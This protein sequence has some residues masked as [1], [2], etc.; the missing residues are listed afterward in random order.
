M[1]EPIHRVDLALAPALIER[2]ERWR[3]R[4]PTI[5]TRAAAIRLLV[6]AGLAA[7]ATSTTVAAPS[8]I[9]ASPGDVPSLPNGKRNGDAQLNVRIPAG[10]YDLVE[11]VAA[12]RA[13]TK[14]EA[15]IFLVND[16]APR[17]ARELG[18]VIE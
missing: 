13:C 15:V 4:Q 14:R 12:V 18:A 2:I 11:W 8:S 3:G 1:A 5:P 17:L 6:E 10:V 9:A 7:G 16:A